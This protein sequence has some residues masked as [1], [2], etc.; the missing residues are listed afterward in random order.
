[1]RNER[2]ANVGKCGV[3]PTKSVAPSATEHA[4]SLYPQS[5]GV[6]I[7]SSPRVI[8]RRIGRTE[9]LHLLN[10]I[11]LLETFHHK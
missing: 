4:G 10:A 2:K 5:T 8:N 1:M 3:E 6:H 7:V 11:Q 9:E